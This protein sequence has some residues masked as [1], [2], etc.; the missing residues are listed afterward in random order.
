MKAA[1]RQGTHR[2]FLRAAW[3]GFLTVGG[4]G[5]AFA[6]ASAPTASEAFSDGEI[7]KL[8]TESSL[9]ASEV[10]A[11]LR[12]HG[13][14]IEEVEGLLGAAPVDSLGE[15]TASPDSAFAV[16]ERI[17]EDEKGIAEETGL[18]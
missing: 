7:S 12:A 1:R 11:S 10:A 15:T 18:I 16:E 3:V 14:S 4:F 5:W 17:E 8:V 9:P 6:Q 2:I 13:V